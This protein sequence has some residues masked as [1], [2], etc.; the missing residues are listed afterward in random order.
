MR[1]RR[2]PR[3]TTLSRRLSSNVNVVGLLFLAVLAALWEAA[4]DFGV[5]RYEYL[6]APHSIAVATAQLWAS[7]ALA[8]NILHT[9]VVAVVGWV[10]SGAAG[11]CLGLFI[12]LQRTAWRYSMASVELLRAV[13]PI[14][15]VP[16]ALLVFGFSSN[17]ELAV[18]AYAGFFPVLVYTAAGVRQVSEVH[19]QVGRVMQLQRLELV[20]KI[21]LP[22]AA[23]SVLVGLRI[24]LALSLA[25]AVVAE[26]VGNAAGIGYAINFAE[27]ALRTPELFAYILSI[28]LVGLLLNLFLMAGFRVLFQ[29]VAR[30]LGES[31]AA[32]AGRGR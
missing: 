29:G 18:T 26:M 28:G 4:V 3:E 12:G 27:Q 15:L 2:L 32:V 6:P 9:V 23:S 11:V 8:Q 10:L 21:V 31:N 14:T 13:P 1:S 7:G 16:A 30:S 5:L 19:W 24:G 22:S 25:L 20:R 17:S